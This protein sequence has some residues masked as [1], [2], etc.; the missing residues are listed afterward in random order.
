M[1]KTEYNP[2]DQDELSGK[3]E[4]LL[5]R[6]VDT[7]TFPDRIYALGGGGRKM[8][9]EMFSQDWVAVEAMRDRS[10]DIDVIFMDSASEDAENHAKEVAD[11]REQL[12]RLEQIMQE[13][14]PPDVNVGSF[15][16]KD[17]LITD[18]VSI[19]NQASLT[20]EDPIAQIKKHTDAEHWWV[21]REHLNSVDD[22]GDFYDVSQGAIK[23]RALGKALHYKALAQ[24]TQ[25]YADAMASNIEE[26]EIAIF[27]GLG[28]GTG[29]GTFIDIARKIRSYNQSA[30]IQLFA[31]LPASGQ[32]DQA[33]ANAFAALSELEYLNLS[34]E[35][36]FNDIYLF[37]L[38][39]TD[40]DGETTANPELR[41][42]DRA[43]T[44]AVLGVYNAT[45]MDY[46]LSNTLSYSPFTIVI[47]QVLHYS[48]DEIKEKKEQIHE[49]LQIKREILNREYDSIEEIESYLQ[50]HHPNVTP[51][52]GDELSDE[53]RT[54]LKRRLREF[55]QLITS[56]LLE[57]LE[58]EITDD[59]DQI[60]DD[61]YGDNLDHDQATIN[62]VVRRRGL[63][64]IIDGIEFIIDIQGI[65]DGRVDNY[66][67]FGDDLINDIAYTELARL[68]R[69]YELLCRLHGA[70]KATME[71]A[72]AEIGTDAD[73]KLLETTLVPS[74]ERGIEKKRWKTLKTARDDVSNRITDTEREL[75]ETEQELEE[76][77]EAFEET[78]DQYTQEFWQ[79]AKPLIDDNA[80]L[81]EM[82]LDETV[83]E[84]KSALS[85]FAENVATE[86][87]VDTVST[88][89]VETALD[90]LK[91]EVDTTLKSDLGRRNSL[92]LSNLE[93]DVIESTSD[94]KVSRKR[95][96]NLESSAEDG[97][98]LSSLFGS[99]DKGALDTDRYRTPYE[100]VKSRGI[101][102]ITR[103]PNTEAAL[104]R[105]GFSVDVEIDV[106]K[107]I[108]QQIEQLQADIR[109]ELEDRYE[110]MV[111]ELIEEDEPGAES[112]VG[113]G[114]SS[115]TPNEVVQRT[116]E[117]GRVVADSAPDELES[118]IADTVTE[119]IKTEIDTDIDE[120][121]EQL[122]QLQERLEMLRSRHER[123]TDAFNLFER[124]TGDVAE[125]LR[126]LYSDYENRFS[127]DI[128]DV[129]HH[130]TKR[131]AIDKLYEHEVTPA[132]L[133]SAVKK[134]S[135]AETD[136]LEEGSTG[137]APQERQDIRKSFS[138]ITSNRILDSRYNGLKRSRL[139]NANIASFPDTGVY[140][141]YAS[142]A[143]SAGQ[144]VD[145]KLNPNDFADVKQKLIENLD[146]SEVSNQYDQW[147]VENGD[148]WEVAMCVYIQG[149][150]FMDNLRDLTANDGYWSRYQ[151][152]ARRR[153]QI[154]TI[155]RHA[156]GLER[157]FYVT[158][159]ELIDIDGNPDFF[160]E[161]SAEDIRSELTSCHDRHTIE[162]E[163]EDI[164]TGQD[165][166]NF[167]ENR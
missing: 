109:Q 33:Q 104:E 62:E 26:S 90:Q 49:V 151:E 53:S 30:N 93:A 157:G 40:L 22:R 117:F 135:L 106:E 4:Y 77:R 82:R 83:R 164:S 132:D 32:R 166:Q 156:F 81:A 58:I 15:N 11:I 145:G 38:E 9:I 46:A 146:I 94:V 44:Y 16:I 158:R 31:T 37:P 150:P 149:L 110:E 28:G 125:P 121:E 18:Y 167:E 1:S 75:E 91:Q 141:A 124:M 79:R 148:P 2:Q 134:Q 60:L 41:E 96:D 105:S 27:A 84:F 126:E 50:K 137:T 19:T 147:F 17:E 160:L 88:A 36:P 14:T 6:E 47:P 56:D 112:D 152:L 64:A 133:S 71:S 86:D 48:R 13:E 7:V 65:Q 144:E 136:L 89:S 70:R 118:R 74:L 23:R 95:W 63:D 127:S 97:G 42:L 155:E 114:D 80:T 72:A 98:F 165:G 35:T 59:S 43:M 39:P 8:V 142:E 129:P 52:E 25:E 103:P 85:E 101:F 115:G 67:E 45:D 55:E 131:H 159:S 76:E 10:Q 119:T 99:E 161:Q 24:G 87:D 108:T 123:I 162:T 163:V 139:N 116:E 140:V 130:R 122:E 69:M 5:E 102:S 29:S 111:Q 154:R 66:A 128:F 54:Y 73:T 34:G 68:T 51:V 153:D 107:R 120:I 61:I 21:Q 143:I 138:K 113:F 57:K 100:K 20:G 78:V 3:L 12:D 92:D